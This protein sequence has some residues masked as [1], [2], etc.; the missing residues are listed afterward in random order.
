MQG[1]YVISQHIDSDLWEI[2]R[3]L[4]TLIAEGAMIE[5]P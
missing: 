5:A 2:L 3:C 1:D 4:F